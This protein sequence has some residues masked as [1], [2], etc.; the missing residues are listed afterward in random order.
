MSTIYRYFDFERYYSIEIRLYESHL[1]TCESGCHLLIHFEH[2]Q[3]F[4]THLGRVLAERHGGQPHH[5]RVRRQLHLKR[6]VARRRAPTTPAWVG[7]VGGG[8]VAGRRLV[9]GGAS[10]RSFGRLR[11]GAQ[12]SWTEHAVDQRL[13]G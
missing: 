3:L 8:F 13:L 10:C 1:C 11:R 12:K 4:R 2:G 7:V 6:R 9:G 5:G